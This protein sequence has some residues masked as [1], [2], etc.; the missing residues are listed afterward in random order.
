M[1]VTHRFTPP[2]C[3]LEIEANN[4]ALSRWTKQRAFKDVQFQLSFDDP[5]LTTEEQVT[6][7]GDRTQLEQLYKA[8]TSYIQNFLQ[9]SFL[10]ETI[11]ASPGSN[12]HD[13]TQPYLEP[14]GLVTHNLFLG[15]LGDSNSGDKIKLNTVQLFDLVTALEDYQTEIVAIPH[16]NSANRKKLPL[17]LKAVASIVA[18]IGLAALGFNIFKHSSLNWQ[19]ASSVQES[20]NSPT[21]S[22]EQSK[23]DDVIPPQVTTSLKNQLLKAKYKTPSPQKKNYHRHHQ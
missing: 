7:K 16:L 10:E 4:S 19:S 5:R 2:T 13:S 20:A 23:K 8:V 6:L 21:R 14:Q 15:S 12:P 17:F 11:S 3:T 9:Q 22:I 1:L 18:I